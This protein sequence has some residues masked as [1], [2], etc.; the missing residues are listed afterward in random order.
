MRNNEERTGALHQ[1]APAPA[2][3]ASSAD[4][5]QHGSSMHF[6]TPTEFVELPSRGL[7]YSEAHP[8]HGEKNIEIKFMT[9]KEEDILTSKTLIKQGIIIDRLLKSLILN[10][11][12]DPKS[13]LSGDRNAILVAARVSGYGPEY[14]VSL[15]CPVCAST[16]RPSFNLEN[17]TLTGAS[18]D[19]EF[20]NKADVSF[21]KEKNTFSFTL[22]KTKAEVEVRLMDG[23]DESKLAS[24]QEM[25]RKNKLPETLMTDLMKAYIVSVNGDKNITSIR[26]F[27]ETMPVIDARELRNVYSKITPNIDLTQHFGCSSCGHEQD[28]EVPFTAEFF[29]PRQ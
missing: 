18:V 7:F 24:N 3:P 26:T 23:K 11:K 15:S 25:K 2:L 20:L 19:E 29:W 5:N 22:P 16:E 8:L 27:I 6:V 4:M 10:T 12:I 13:L 1:D 17:S 9:A 28:M 21:N 14:N